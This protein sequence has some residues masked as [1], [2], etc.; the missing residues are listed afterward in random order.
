MSRDPEE[1]D[2]R[3][4]AVSPLAKEVDDFPDE[5]LA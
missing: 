2:R 5:V 1:F 3:L 4:K